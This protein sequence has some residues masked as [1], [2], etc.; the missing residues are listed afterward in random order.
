MEV[1]SFWFLRPDLQLPV[2]GGNCEALNDTI[3]DLRVITSSGSETSQKCEL[4]KGVR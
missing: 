4:R 1:D 2:S 3:D